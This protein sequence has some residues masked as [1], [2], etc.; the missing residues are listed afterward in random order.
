MRKAELGRIALWAGTQ[1]IDAAVLQGVLGERADQ[2]EVCCAFGLRDIRGSMEDGTCKKELLDIARS[3]EDFHDI[4]F[5]AL[6][7]QGTGIVDVDCHGCDEVVEK[8]TWT[9][10]WMRENAQT[11]KQFVIVCC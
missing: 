7:G 10:S 8:M 1:E 3:L 2:E 11:N 5:I 9:N 6:E 4:R